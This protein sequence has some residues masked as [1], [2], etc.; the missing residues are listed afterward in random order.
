MNQKE[1]NKT[2]VKKKPAKYPPEIKEEAIR[3]FYSARSGFKT[4]IE[5]AEHVANLLGIGCTRTIEK[6]IRQAEIDSGTREGTS[7]DNLEE[8][9]RLRRGNAELRRTNGI[10][11]A[12]SAFFAA[13][14]DRPQS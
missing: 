3:L 6:W 14:L 13:E 9:R 1:S 2:S 5:T 10:L 12:A 8:L 11:K 4:K 7:T